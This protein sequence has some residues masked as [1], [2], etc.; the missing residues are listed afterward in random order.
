MQG[1]ESA[2]KYKW[3]TSPM[4]MKLEMKGR[5]FQKN[6][7]TFRCY[8]CLKDSMKKKISMIKAESKSSLQ[9]GPEKS[10]STRTEDRGG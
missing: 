2:N 1:S 8:V 4:G 9:P 7:N 3:S 10:S 5:C 6:R